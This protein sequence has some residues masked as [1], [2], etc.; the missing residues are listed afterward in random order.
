M[1]TH[2]DVK[3]LVTVSLA[4]IFAAGDFEGFLDLISKKAGHEVLMDI[5]YKIVGIADET[6]VQLEVTGCVEVPEVQDGEEPT[7]AP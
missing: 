6:S 7:A 5:D 4:E 3:E 2:C 1:K